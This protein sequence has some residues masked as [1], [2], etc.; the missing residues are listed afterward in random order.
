MMHLMNNFL[1]F[2]L[3]VFLPVCFY[4]DISPKGPAR[5]ESSVLPRTGHMLAE[6]NGAQ[7]N[8]NEYSI[9][10]HRKNYSNLITP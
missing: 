1:E 9:K 4:F 5:R 7:T 6:P 8:P 3:A 10:Q 2:L